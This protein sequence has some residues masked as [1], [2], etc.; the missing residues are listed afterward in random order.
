ME[1]N[2]NIKISYSPCFVGILAELNGIYRGWSDGS[3]DW[4]NQTSDFL[5]DLPPLPAFDNALFQTD[6]SKKLLDE[7]MMIVLAMIAGDYPAIRN[8]LKGTEFVFIIGYPRTGGSYLTKSIIQSF[9]LNHKEIPEPLAH[10]GFPNIM[11][12]WQVADGQKPLSY[13]YESFVQLAE[14]LVISKAYYQLKAKSNQLISYPVVKKIHKAVHSGHGLKMLFNPGQADYLMTF[15]N[16][17]PVAIS[18]YEKSGG[19]PEDGLF[20]ATRQR[21]WIESM[22]VHD[23]TM[24]GYSLTEIAAMDYYQAVEKS[25]I[26]FYSKLAISGFF[27]G[28]KEGVRLIPYGQAPLQETVKF[29]Q[30]KYQLKNNLEAVYIH[31]KSKQFPDYI[32][33]SKATVKAMQNHWASL[34]LNFPNL[35]L[36]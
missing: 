12:R 5:S 23:L 20:P 27:S 2:I 1:F 31:K 19:L 16:P 33:K 22:I 8:Y 7:V 35:D 28:S 24:E 9:G 13:L 34:G 6:L 3:Y 4:A 29:Y 11:D 32:K 14:F 26:R 36:S 17:L 18:I 15:R 10:D 21:S 30:E 25:W